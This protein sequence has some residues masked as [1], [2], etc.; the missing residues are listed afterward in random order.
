MFTPRIPFFLLLLYSYITSL[1]AM[2]H[3]ALDAG[4][5]PDSKPRCF[6]PRTFHGNYTVLDINDCNNAIAMLPGGGLHLHPEPNKL[7]THTPGQL[8]EFNLYRHPHHA[9]VGRERK[10][11]L[12]AAFRAGSCLV[13]VRPETSNKPD[14]MDPYGPSEAAFYMWTLIWP[15]VKRIATNIVKECALTTDDEPVGEVIKETRLGDK[16]F[17]YQVGVMGVARHGLTP[18]APEGWQVTFG[19]RAQSWDFMDTRV[20]FGADFNLYE[21]GGT[22]EGKGTKGLWRSED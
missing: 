16:S 11:F 4:D 14:K 20:P 17:R 15:Q 6:V 21:A 18:F 2:N 3:A 22:W 19:W 9:Q 8:P 1:M 5:A 7:G 12:P 10:F 13:L